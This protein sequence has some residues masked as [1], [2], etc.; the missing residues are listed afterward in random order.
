MS[1]D[2]NPELVR[3]RMEDILH[4]GAT[5][6]SRLWG[7]PMPLAVLILTIGYLLWINISGWRGMGWAAAFVVPLWAIGYKQC[8]SDPYGINVIL[9]WS[10]TVIRVMDSW[11][12]ASVNPLPMKPKRPKWSLADALR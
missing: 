4:V 7:L 9:S 6:Q 12:G 10:S 1:E 11:G 2:D 3:R 5:R 8:S